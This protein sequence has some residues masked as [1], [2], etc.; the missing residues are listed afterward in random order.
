MVTVPSTDWDARLNVRW[1]CMF[2]LAEAKL[3]KTYLF[4]QLCILTSLL[5]VWVIFYSSI[6][7]VVVRNCRFYHT[8]EKKYFS[9]SAKLV[10]PN[11]WPSVYNHP[12][13]FILYPSHCL[14]YY[15]VWLIW[16]VLQWASLTAKEGFTLCMCIRILC[17]W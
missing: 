5:A 9:Y 10:V 16:I 8:Y 3:K 11:I 13:I 4:V 7:G 12:I 2:S 17:V 6:K 14:L 15:E 1:L